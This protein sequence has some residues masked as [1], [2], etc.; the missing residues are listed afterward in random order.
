MECWDIDPS[1]TT[2]VL[3]IVKSLHLKSL[4][5]KVFSYILPVHPAHPAHPAHPTHPAH[6]AEP[7]PDLFTS[8]QGSFNMCGCEF[9]G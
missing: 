6:P 7:T 5:L 2:G 1:K 9:T 4:K 8:P 3:Y